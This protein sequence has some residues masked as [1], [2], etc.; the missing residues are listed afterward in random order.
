MRNRSNVV[1]A[2]KLEPFMVTNTTLDPRSPITKDLVQCDRQP[3]TGIKIIYTQGDVI[4]G[5]LR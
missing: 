4:F 2:L 3:W 5:P 1:W